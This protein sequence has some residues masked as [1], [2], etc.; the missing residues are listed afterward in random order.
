MII[1]VI[2]TANVELSFPEIKKMLCIQLHMLRKNSST[3]IARD[4]SGLVQ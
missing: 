2:S 1:D 4:L 3:T